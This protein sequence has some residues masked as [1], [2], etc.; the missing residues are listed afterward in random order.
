VRLATAFFGKGQFVATELETQDGAW[1]LRQELE[2]PYYQP[3]S[4]E[5]IARS[6]VGAG[7]ALPGRTLRG[8]SNVQRLAATVTIREKQGA[9]TLAIVVEGT[10]RVPVAVEFAFRHGGK[11][12]GVEPLPG[13]R[14]AFLLRAGE[15][16]YQLGGDSIRF[17][18]G[19]AEH[20]YTQLRGALPKWD[21][22]SVYLTGLT[23]FE[24]TLQ[25][26]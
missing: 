23:P 9:F 22:Q 19:H 3:F 10:E 2:G 21:G 18:P 11:L 26:G 25:I 14:D 4:P 20:T 7:G 6:G 16:R 17:G 24:I 15:G 5:Q 8:K 1:V 12:E 13:L